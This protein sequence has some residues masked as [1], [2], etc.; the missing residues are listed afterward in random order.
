MYNNYYAY[1]TYHRHG[2][3]KVIPPD[4]HNQPLRRG[5]EC[6]SDSDGTD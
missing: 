4:Q 6:D 5:G 1:T 3:I 2:I